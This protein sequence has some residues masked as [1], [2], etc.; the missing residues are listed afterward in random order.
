MAKRN[1]LP[2]IRFGIPHH[3]RWYRKL[4]LFYKIFKNNKS[5]YLFNLIPTKNSNYDIKNRDKY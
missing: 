2:G 3:R 1:N 5:I 4:Y